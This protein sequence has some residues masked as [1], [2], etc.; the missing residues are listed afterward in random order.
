MIPIAQTAGFVETPFTFPNSMK[1]PDLYNG[2][3]LL[4]FTNVG[5]KPDDFIRLEFSVS[6]DPTIDKL[7]LWVKIELFSRI[8]YPSVYDTVEI[9]FIA[10]PNSGGSFNDN[11]VIN[12]SGEP[13][14]TFTVDD[15]LML[16]LWVDDTD[17]T[18]WT[19]NGFTVVSLDDDS[20]GK[21]VVFNLLGEACA[22]DYSND[23]SVTGEGLPIDGA[24][25]A[26]LVN[27]PAVSTGFT[28]P[29]DTDPIGSEPSNYVVSVDIEDSSPSV[30]FS[31]ALF[32]DGADVRVMV[33]GET[34]STGNPTVSFD[35][36][37][38]NVITKT[39]N[40]GNRAIWKSA[41]YQPWIE[42]EI[43]A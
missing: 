21:L 35:A 25:S 12:G 17:N 4:F 10:D 9:S 30:F 7:N 42:S 27:L 14:R 36:S 5:D 15:R 38:L 18:T 13:S 28:A 16:C 2:Y 8:V 37:V 6:S 34:I 41:Y 1:Y 39:F 40:S 19:F 22:I 31:R 33:I 29:T 11:L 43:L 26:S 23:S 3:K 24:D 32:V 20:F